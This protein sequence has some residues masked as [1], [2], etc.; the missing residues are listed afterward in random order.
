M[1]QMKIFR[2]IMQQKQAV[3]VTALDTIKQKQDSG[4]ITRPVT[5]EPDEVGENDTEEPAQLTQNTN[6][7]EINI[8]NKRVNLGRQRG[9]V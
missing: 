5:P 3:R 4:T 7:R 9:M 6:I 2:D 8:G 1:E